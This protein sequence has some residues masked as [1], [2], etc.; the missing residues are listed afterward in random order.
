M[1]KAYSKSSRD[2]HI[3]TDD[4]LKE[5]MDDM[6]YLQFRSDKWRAPQRIC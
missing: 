5:L 3:R 4:T 6:M 1:Y 2:T